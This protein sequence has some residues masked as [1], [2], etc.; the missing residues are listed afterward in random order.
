V[1]R[2]VSRARGSAR[3]KVARETRRRG[4]LR[5]AVIRRQLIC[6]HLPCFSSPL[7]NSVRTLVVDCTPQ[8]PPSRV[9]FIPRVECLQ[10]PPV[11]YARRALP[12][13]SAPL[14]LALDRCRRQGGRAL[15]YLS[16]AEGMV[17]FSESL[18]STSEIFFINRNAGCEPEGA[19]TR[20]HPL[21]FTLRSHFDLVPIGARAP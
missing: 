14:P 2:S 8:P 10:H 5:T 12:S 1:Q 4:S 18:A 15:V 11:P 3:C 21:F 6:G 7:R 17:S 9:R 19:R 20:V 13:R 16:S